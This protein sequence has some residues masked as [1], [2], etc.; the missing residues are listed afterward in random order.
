M[1]HE[2]IPARWV[3]QSCLSAM[4][5]MFEAFVYFALCLGHPLSICGNQDGVYKFGII[6]L[7][8]WG[9]SVTSSPTTVKTV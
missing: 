2:T 3:W 6:A 7:G 9:G 5:A 4:R 8:I 1:A